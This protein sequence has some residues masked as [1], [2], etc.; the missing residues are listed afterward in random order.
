MSDHA[1]LIDRRRLLSD[2]LDEF[3]AL[4]IDI[5]NINLFYDTFFYLNLDIMQFFYFRICELCL[6]IRL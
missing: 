1:S 5:K 2:E 4:T 6:V 3:F